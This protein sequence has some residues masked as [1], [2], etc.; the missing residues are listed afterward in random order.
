MVRR[1]FNRKLNNIQSLSKYYL[2]E[3]IY[4]NNQMRS[5]CRIKARLR[6]STD[7]LSEFYRQCEAIVSIM[8]N[9]PFKA[10]E[11]YSI[12][13]IKHVYEIVIE[14]DQLRKTWAW[15]DGIRNR[16]K[17]C[18]IGLNGANSSIVLKYNNP[19]FRSRKQIKIS[20]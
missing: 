12:D 14:G 2:Q 8:S 1:I 17:N 6:K 9:Q 10:Y 16:F 20:I 4:T 13:H 3:T 18:I 5:K 15:I 19:R 7:K 11:I